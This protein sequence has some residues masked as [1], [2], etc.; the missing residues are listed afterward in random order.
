LRCPSTSPLVERFRGG[1]LDVCVVLDGPLQ[2]LPVGLDV[3]AYRVV[4]ESLTKAL[5]YA[6][7]RP[8]RV[9]S[10]H[11]Y[12]HRARDPC[13]RHEQPGTVGGSGDRRRDS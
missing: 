8:D 13:L 5:K 7:G 10:P 6:A 2:S 3:S 9:A 1:G 12:A 11:A 4:Q